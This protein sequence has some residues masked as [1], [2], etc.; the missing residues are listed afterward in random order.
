[1]FDCIYISPLNRVLQTTKLLIQHDK[2]KYRKIIVVP[3]LTEVVSKICDFGDRVQDKVT[4]YGSYFDFT[5][6]TGKNAENS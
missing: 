2:L 6:L 4:K 3:E 5:L 1:M